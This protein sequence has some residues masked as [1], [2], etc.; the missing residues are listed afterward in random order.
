M[1]VLVSNSVSVSPP[2]S[3]QVPDTSAPAGAVGIQG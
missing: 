3:L 2:L 1:W